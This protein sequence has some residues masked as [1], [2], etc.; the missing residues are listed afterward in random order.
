MPNNWLQVLV[1]GLSSGTL[2]TGFL[3]IRRV[4]RLEFQVETMW[5]AF[6]KRYG[7]IHLYSDEERRRT[8]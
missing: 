6:E 4:S 3:I 1:T 2:I 8:K 5:K 7:R